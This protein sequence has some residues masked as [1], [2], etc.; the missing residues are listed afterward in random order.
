M[1]VGLGQLLGCWTGGGSAPQFCTGL[2]GTHCS[3]YTLCKVHTVPGT[4]CTGTGGSQPAPEKTAAERQ[5][6]GFRQSTGPDPC[7]LG[8][9]AVF[10]DSKWNSVDRKQ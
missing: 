10:V 9:G 3:R 8:S 4:H 1:A 7:P 5:V 6:L 2:P